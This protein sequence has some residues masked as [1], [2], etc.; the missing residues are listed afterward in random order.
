MKSNKN[1]STTSRTSSIDQERLT[2]RPEY[3]P[4]YHKEKQKISSRVS[5]G[6]AELDDILH[7]GFIPRRAYLVRGDS[8]CGKTTLGMHFLCAGAQRNEATLFVSL[9]E[10]QDHIYTDAASIGLDM[11]DVAFLDLSA[12]SRFFTQMESYDLLDPTRH[13]NLGRR[14]GL[15]PIAFSRTQ[16]RSNLAMEARLLRNQTRSD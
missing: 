10:S 14:Q 13:C 6:V 15:H 11:K 1:A 16:S 8:G 4:D 12:N 2:N 7:G 3:V 5:T 9:G